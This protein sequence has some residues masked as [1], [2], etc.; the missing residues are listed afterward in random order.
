MPIYHNNHEVLLKKGSDLEK[1]QSY[2]LWTE[3][4]SNLSSAIFP[5]GDLEKFE[6]RK[7]AKKL[8]FNNYNKKDSVG[9]CFI[10]KEILKNF[11]K[12][13]FHQRLEILLIKKWENIGRT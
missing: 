9:I 11:Y 4:T 7:Q 13:I 6:I 3:S 10:M 8:G 12:L 5:I 2:F 1:D